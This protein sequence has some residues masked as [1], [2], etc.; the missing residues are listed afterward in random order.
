[1]GVDSCICVSMKSGRETSGIRYFRRVIKCY[2]LEV[3]GA[4]F[5]FS[6][7]SIRIEKKVQGMIPVAMILQ[8]SVD[9][10]SPW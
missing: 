7:D 1:M 9:R 5:L 4:S 6:E 10:I 3:S 8:F 2:A